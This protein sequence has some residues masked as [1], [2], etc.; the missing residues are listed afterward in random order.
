MTM[1]RQQG[2]TETVPV[3]VVIPTFGR[4]SAILKVLERLSQCRP[5]PAAVVIHVDAATDSTV[6][7]I[8]ERFP[9]AVV[10]TSSTRLGP[11]GGRHRALMICETP[12]AVSFDDDSYPIDAGFFSEV[13]RLFSRNP[14][15]A[16]LAAQ[17]W[18]RNE[19]VAELD[20]W[21]FDRPNF[22]G[23]G[24]AVRVEAYRN[25]RGYLPRPVA[26]GIEETDVSLQLFAAGWRIYP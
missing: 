1:D 12:F 16:I 21:M 10:L 9:D 18:H 3:S 11:G 8:N 4:G 24:F 19:P 6:L 23:C 5:S 20:N 22:I 13:V 2:N 7:E 17:I 26:Y 25:V 14:D 15:V